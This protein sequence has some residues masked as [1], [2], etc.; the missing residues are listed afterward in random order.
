VRIVALVVAAVLGVSGGI[1]TAFLVPAGVRTADVPDVPVPL[2]AAQDPL[3]LGV[4]LQNLDECT[5]ESVIMVGWGDIYSAL[6][7]SITDWPDATYLKTSDSCDTV[8]PRVRGEIP[9]YVAYLPPFPTP[10]AACEERMSARHK[11]NFVTRM[12]AD[13]QDGVPC[14]CAVDLATLPAIGEGQELTTESGMWTYLYQGMLTKIGFDLAR[15]RTGNFGPATTFATRQLQTDAALS[16]LGYVDT[17]TW[18]VL[19]S[20]ACGRYVY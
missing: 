7:N 4:A 13:N 14:A 3:G 6:S 17:D 15:D 8:Y 9:E 12:R 11:G 19:R 10:E 2:T 16:P 18:G 5:G 1:V 20:K